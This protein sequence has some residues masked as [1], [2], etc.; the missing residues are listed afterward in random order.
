MGTGKMLGK[1][2]RYLQRYQPYLYLREVMRAFGSVG[3][4]FRGG[5]TSLMPIGSP[6][7]NVL[8]SYDNRGLGEKLRG[9]AVPTSHPQFF[10]TIVMAQTF[11]DLGYSVDVIHCEN[12]KFVPWKPYDVVVDTR[13]NLQRLHK[14]FPPGCIKIL[15]CDTAHIVFQ[16]AAEMN[17]MLDLQKRKGVT[18][19]ANRLESLH[20]GVE[21][22]DY[23]TTCGNE[24]TMKTYG[25]ADKPIF[26]LPIPAQR[27]WPWP[28][29]KD[30]D[31][32]RRRFLWFGSRGM[33]H[34]GLDLVL[35]AF[36]EM[37]EVHLTIV[38]PVQD[39]P[40]FVDLYRNELF[41]TTN[42]SLV[43]WL[44]NTGPEF[45]A[46]LD[47]SVA[48]VFPS[49]SE[50]GA[51]CVLESMAGGVIPLVTYEASVDVEDFGELLS[52]ASV[53]QIKEG[54]RA[55]ASMPTEELQHRAKRAW[56]YVH[57]NNTPENFTKVYRATVEMILAKHGK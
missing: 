57:V 31:V 36:L 40:E 45:K 39:E 42:I 30:F 16:N 10:K 20:M 13:F 25:Y 55:I 19:P 34:K 24:F 56:E 52:G 14:W 48:H 11:L 4:Q 23:L 33:I 17:R 12:Q 32:C 29:D 41:H 8:I 47:Q 9:G 46:L 38:G 2:G 6:K 21:Y 18:V 53:E 5:V 44:D 54:V 26:R 37:P 15:H 50:A 3:K 51:A 1:A 22:A 49:C 28:Y 27:M 35:E 7:G 43:G